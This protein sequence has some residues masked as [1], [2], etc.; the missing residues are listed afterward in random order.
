MMMVM[1]VMMVM[2][3]VVVV[4]TVNT[5]RE[6]THSGGWID[7]W[8]CVGLSMCK[9]V[10][11]RRLSTAVANNTAASVVSVSISLALGS[12]MS[13]KACMHALLSAHTHLV[14]SS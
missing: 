11:V 7:G 8:C 3:M 1:M 12:V 5:K 10:C 6:V 13:A 14:D 4:R 9:C 2:M